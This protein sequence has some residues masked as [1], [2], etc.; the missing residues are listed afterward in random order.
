M[1]DLR[2]TAATLG[3]DP[4]TVQAWLG[5]SSMTLAVDTYA[6]YMGQDAD[7]AAIA[8][9][10]AI[11]GDMSGTTRRKLRDADQDATGADR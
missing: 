4:K 3:V 10:N 8:R 7:I 5:H 6:H 11:L 9:I 2:H 1:Q